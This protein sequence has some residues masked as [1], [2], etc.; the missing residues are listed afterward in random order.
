MHRVIYLF[1]Q[2]LISDVSLTGQDPTT[3]CSAIK[4]YL[5]ELEP[6][7]IP[8]AIYDDFMGLL[9]TEDPTASLKA[10]IEGLPS[11]HKSAFAMIMQH[12]KKV[13]DKSSVNQMTPSNLGIVLVCFW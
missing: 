10:F 8:Y 5:R 3:V 7:L 9:A 1:W 12:L 2:D 4:L 13:S 6:P 11:L